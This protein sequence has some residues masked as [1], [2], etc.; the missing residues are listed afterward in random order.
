MSSHEVS[1]KVDAEI[2]GNEA[3]GTEDQQQV[4]VEK[5][6]RQRATRAK[7]SPVWLFFEEVRVPSKKKKGE[8]EIKGKC[9]AC[10][11]LFA[12][13]ASGTTSHWMRHLTTC[14][15]H[16]LNQKSKQQKIINFQTEEEEEAEGDVETPS[17]VNPDY[18]DNARIREIICKLIIVHDMPFRIVEYKWFNI[19]MKALNRG[20]K[21]MSRN[22]IRNECMKLYESEKDILKKYFKNVRKI[23]LTCDLWTSN[24]T[25]CYMSLVAHYIDDDWKMHC[26]IINF[27][28]LE[29]P[30]SGV[31]ISNA[32][33][34]CLAAWKIED[35]VASITFDNAA[36]N[37]LAVKFLLAKFK[38][39][40]ALW[41]EGKFLH[42]RC[43]AHILNLV[44]QDGLK[45]IGHL[46]DKV[47]ETIKY[48]KKSNNRFYKFQNDIDSLNIGRSKGMVL[49]CC[50]RWGS[51]FKMLD[52]AFHYRAAIDAYAS[53]DAN[54][55]WQPSDEEWL[56]YEQVNSVLGVF[57]AATK[58]FSGSTYPTSNLFYPHIVNIKKIICGL[59]ES[60]KECIAAMADAMAEKFDKY[61]GP[62]CNTLFAIAAILDPR[63]KMDM[64]KFTF[65]SLYEEN[66]VAGKLESVET[67]L[68]ELYALYE[69]ENN[70]SMATSA[71]NE[72]TS[73]CTS[74]SASSSTTAFSI[75]S[76]YQEYMKAKNAYQPLKSDL[77]RYLDDEI[78]NIPDDKFDILSWWK[79]NELK[80]PL[81][82]KIARDIL[83]IPVTSVSS[84]SAFSTGGRVV[85]DY[86]SSLL[87]STVQC[88]VCTSSWIRG[89][90][91][92]EKD[93]DDD[94][95]SI[96]LVLVEEDSLS[97]N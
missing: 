35:K 45:M 56:L 17:V 11:K 97:D 90:H 19:L 40:K 62:E 36:S 1:N 55:R 96:P 81:V 65:P 77:K 9:M 59:K 7:K 54:Y 29:P 46:T 85:D 15:R 25:I 73:Q 50:T 79:M 16:K 6:K 33:Y 38:N 22:T 4:V 8:I 78:E 83:T 57:H 44:V 60:K 69:S 63:F 5:E 26:R 88:L 94:A 2:G 89:G 24:Q 87:P 37:D 71:N 53:G 70:K 43:C 39:R 30:H 10:Q 61:W 80:Y 34:D 76:Q 67:T 68:R 21:K 47:R 84:E 72:S 64:I 20:Y 95:N 74:T 82:A 13:T 91:H 42:V 27:I 3:T 49:D 23:S 75:T 28:E 66:E 93:M 51:T 32:P 52:S 14:D 58:A 48:I 41:F 86:R 18:C 31:V 12:K 92:K